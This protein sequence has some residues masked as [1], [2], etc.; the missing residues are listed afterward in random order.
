LTATW[1]QSERKKLAVE[2]VGG[3]KNAVELGEGV[4]MRRSQLK[5][6]ARLRNI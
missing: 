2:Y 5:F 1:Y 4:V 3:E 6:L